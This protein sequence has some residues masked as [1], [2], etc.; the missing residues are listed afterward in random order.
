MTIA[1]TVVVLNR[2]R[3]EDVGPPARVYL[4]P[5]T[6]FSATFM[7]DSNILPGTVTQAAGGGVEVETALGPLP[8]P[9]RAAVGDKVHLSLRPEQLSLADW[10]GAVPMGSARVAEMSFQ[11]TH[12]RCRCLVGAHELLLRVPV[13]S[14]VG[15]DATVELFARPEDIVLLTR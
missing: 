14:G 15:V 11:G 8:A 4:K 2:G 12:L 7:G 9:G 6:L 3:I 5:A 1:D 10:G 13:E